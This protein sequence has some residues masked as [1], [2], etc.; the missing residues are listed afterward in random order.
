MLNDLL[1]DRLSEIIQVCDLH[2]ERLMHA[3]DFL[4]PFQAA[5][6]DSRGGAN[7]ENPLHTMK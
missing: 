4:V 5:S 6:N 7:R 1:K 2:H 3:I